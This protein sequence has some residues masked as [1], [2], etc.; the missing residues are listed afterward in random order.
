VVFPFKDKE[1]L[2][3]R[4]LLVVK[5]TLNGQ[6]KLTD[7]RAFVLASYDGQGKEFLA[8][9]SPRD[10]YCLAAD[11]ESTEYKIPG[12][13]C[14]VYKSKS[15]PYPPLRRDPTFAGVSPTVMWNLRPRTIVAPFKTWSIHEGNLLALYGQGGLVPV[16]GKLVERDVKLYRDWAL[17]KGENRLTACQQCLDKSKESYK[18]RQVTSGTNP[19]N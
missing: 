13:K 8:T 6:G 19:S 11:V 9:L 12:H 16:V 7:I 17:G 10:C 5:T 3:V 18:S 4:L 14:S 1:V 2:A 15:C